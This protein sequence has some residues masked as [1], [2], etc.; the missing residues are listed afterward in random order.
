MFT[1]IKDK[2][3][4]FIGRNALAENKRYLEELLWASIFN[5]SIAS[6]TWLKNRSFSPGR[7]AAGYPALY[8]L[9]R[10]IN[11]I[12]PNKILEFGLGESTKITAQYVLNANNKAL[13]TVIDHNEE[14]LRFFSENNNIEASK[15]TK[16]LPLEQR[17]FFNK[18]CTAYQNLI[19]NISGHKYDL[20]F[21]DG[22]YG[23]DDFSRSQIIDVIENDLLSENFIIIFDDTDRFGEQQTLKKIIELFENKKVKYHLGKYTG[24][25]HTDIICCEKYKF[26]CSL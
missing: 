19:K 1:F 9:F 24:L 6:S 25:K 7:W 5:N 15:Y 16:I 2:I 22:P 23:S 21:I 20:I 26:L 13:L 11:D 14:W 18:D 4:S 3:K 8:I 12:K 17:K 10:S